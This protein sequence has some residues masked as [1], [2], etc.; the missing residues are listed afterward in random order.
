MEW[1]W[2]WLLARSGE[3]HALGVFLY[4]EVYSEQG[5]SGAHWGRI[6]F[7]VDVVFW[8]IG[9]EYSTDCFEVT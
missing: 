9:L 5:K 3:N 2:N 4:W 6:V 7:G 1:S 8:C